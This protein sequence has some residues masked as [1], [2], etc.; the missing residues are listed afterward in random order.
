MLLLHRLAVAVGLL[1]LLAGCQRAPSPVN[2]VADGKP[3]TLAEWH[4]VESD[5]K[6][7]SL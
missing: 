4:V 2:F 3:A 1:S 6:R 7:L 5:G